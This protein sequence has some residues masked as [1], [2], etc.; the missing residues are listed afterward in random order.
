LDGEWNLFP[1]ELLKTGA[2]AA[3][4]ILTPGNNDD[5][6][7]AEILEHR[8]ESGADIIVATNDLGM[9][10]KLRAF[11]IS[12]V[13]IPDEYRLPDQSSVLIHKLKAE[14]ARAQ[15][16]A[17][18]PTVEFEGAKDL[19]QIS[20]SPEAPIDEQA[21]KA[22][23]AEVRAKGERKFELSE[24][25]SYEAGAIEDYREQWD[26]YELLYLAYLKADR[27]KRF[28]SFKLPFFVT[29]KGAVAA[30]DTELT[31]TFSAGL[32]I[33]WEPL[34]QFIPPP[35]APTV[36]PS[37]GQ[38]DPRKDGH[39]DL[40]DRFLWEAFG[41]SKPGYKWH[42]SFSFT[43]PRRNA[44][45]KMDD[46]T[47]VVTFRIPH[48]RQGESRPLKALSVVFDEESK[49]RPFGLTWTAISENGVGVKEGECHVKF[50]SSTGET[51]Q[52]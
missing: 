40:L 35:A 13:R 45:L 3:K 38:P 12:L 21:L 22:T 26:R 32:Q 2:E 43:W 36:P 28:R 41:R 39:L 48:L 33:R 9:H 4:F 49:I 31:L 23:V 29:N 6:I 16:A 30:K 18:A 7:I 5:R 51:T 27:V 44:K 42:W 11:G 50:S 52:G 10:L 1:V 37:K 15:S 8:Q 46:E 19:L 20:S 25:A 24:A 47:S 14:L 34:F 17:P